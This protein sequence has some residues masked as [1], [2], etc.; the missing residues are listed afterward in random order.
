VNVDELETGD[1]QD[2]DRSDF[3]LK[4]KLT[5]MCYSTVTGSKSLD[6]YVYDV[7]ECIDLA[8]PKNGQ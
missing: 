4:L 7:V 1:E 5:V 6:V 2:F 8:F 3:V